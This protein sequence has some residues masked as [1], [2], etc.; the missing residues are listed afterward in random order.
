MKKKSKMNIQ[1]SLFFSGDKSLS[2]RA[3]IF[4]ALATGES[5]IF[6]F[7]PAEDTLNTLK[8]FEQL[9]CKLTKISETDYI[10]NSPGLKQWQ[11]SPGE[12]N[13]GNSG[14]GA[15]LLLGLFGGIPGFEASLDG[16]S[17]LR[18]R[19]MKR[20]TEPLREVGAKFESAD[21]L[22]INI[23]G[24]Q[25]KDIHFTE[26][27]GSAQVKS[28]MLLAALGSSAGV[29][30]K[31]PIESRNHTE[32]MLKFCGV[33]IL[34]QKN[35]GVREIILQPPYDFA[36]REY[37]IW[38]DISSAAF[39]VVAGLLAD[40][41]ELVLRNVLLNRFRDRYLTVLKRM[42]GNIEIL[43]QS[44]QCGEPGGDIIVYPSRL[45][46]TEILPDE[47]PALIDELPILTIAG[48]FAEGK[49][50]FSGAEE[51]RV[52]ESDRISGMVNNLRN[53]GVAVEEFEDGLHL[54]GDP[55]RMLKGEVDSNMDHRI[56]MSFE[57]ANMRSLANGADKAIKIAGREWV[58]TSFP[59]FYSKLEAVSQNKLN[60]NKKLEVIA[61][62]GPAGSGKST[63]AAELSKAY[64]FFQVDSGAMYRAI[65]FQ[66]LLTV[67]EKEVAKFVQQQEFLQLLEN[68]NWKIEFDHDKNQ[69]IYLNGKQLGQEIR[70]PEITKF[71]KYIA[72]QPSA[73]QKVNSEIRSLKDKY[74]P[75]VVDGRDIGTVVFPDADIKFYI[76][77]DVEERAKRRFVEFSQKQS[78]ITLDEVIHQIVTRDNQDISRKE[79][80]LRPADD[81]IF[82]DTTSRNINVALRIV[83][84]YL[85]TSQS[86]TFS[87]N[88][89]DK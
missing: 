77:A 85:R 60:S 79:G 33:E 9:G 76:T 80:G 89:S 21:K 36:A 15:R 73:R 72:D 66:T 7:L 71:I 65:T 48:L 42:G 24:S 62:D 2:H 34:E 28:A 69:I 83:T 81:A 26:K 52:K 75:M 23:A 39:F 1:G 11:K 16:D 50:A 37:K 57:I 44:N 51:L 32:N 45:R 22:P 10:V 64:N 38:G 14:T 61:I 18:K 53:T 41:G 3:A 6:N 43:P 58:N 30:L 12:L 20:V 27:L 88:A 67:P 17:S 4:S 70:T 46:G 29:H 19:P 5:K 31:E 82:I 87:I 13:V 40:S 56:V 63:L 78:G 55:N 74:S 25:L 49:F 86:F 84:S 47:I 8:I 59:D 54:T 68:L 35:E